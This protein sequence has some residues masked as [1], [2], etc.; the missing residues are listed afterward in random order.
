MTYWLTFTLV[1]ISIMFADI[2]WAQYF[3]YISKQ[4]SLLSGVWGSLIYITGAYSM[5]NI[6]DDF[7]FVIAGALGGCLGTVLTVEWN[8][9]KKS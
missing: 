7:S 1:F 5:F 9:R 8:K 2:C 3:H 4:K 6:V